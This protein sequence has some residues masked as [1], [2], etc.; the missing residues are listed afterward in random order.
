MHWP[1]HPGLWSKP[2]LGETTK[3]GWPIKTRVISLARE[4]WLAETGILRHFLGSLLPIERIQIMHGLCTSIVIAAS[5]PRSLKMLASLKYLRLRREQ[6]LRLKLK[7]GC[8]TRSEVR[9]KIKL[10]WDWDKKTKAWLKLSEAET[11]SERKAENKTE[12]WLRLKLK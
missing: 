6:K 8:V 10:K 7:W 4:S 5:V 12:V 9:M 1:Q 2:V 11:R 3:S